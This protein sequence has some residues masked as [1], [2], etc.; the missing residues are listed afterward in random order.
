MTQQHAHEVTDPVCGMK[1]DPHRTEHRAS[2][3]GK[4]WYFCS[5]RCRHK[6]EG[7]PDAYLQGDQG[8]DSPAEPAPPGTIYTCPMH[9]EIRQEG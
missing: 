2:H 6:F 7:D 9:P 1:V 3:G 5:A 8:D 4:T